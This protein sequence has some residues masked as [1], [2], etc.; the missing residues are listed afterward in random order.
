MNERIKALI[1]PMIIIASAI[2][3]VCCLIKKPQTIDDFSSHISYAVSGVCI[4]FVLYERVLWKQIPWNRPPILKKEYKGLIN[5]KYNDECVSKAIRIIV[6]QSWL[7]VNI[8]T[9]TDIN[10][11]HTVTGTILAEHGTSVLYYTYIT[12]PSAVSQGE[13]PI[14]YGTC[15]MIIDGDNDS[16]ITGRYWT[17]SRT[18]GDIEWH[19]VADN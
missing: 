13:N 7:S 17:S 4:L 9:A 15:R 5:Y 14:Q 8:K 1:R 16:N 10:S 2:F 12:N 3:A 6:K 19:A 11:S 18:V